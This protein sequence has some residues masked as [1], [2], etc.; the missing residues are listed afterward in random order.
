[1]LS[2]S[3]LLLAQGHPLERAVQE[4][5]AAAGLE[6]TLFAGEPAV[7]Q[8]ILVKCDPR[9]RVWT[10]QYLQYPNPAGLK[11]VQV[12]RWSRTVYDRVPKPPPEGPRGADRI[13]IL[14][15]ADGDGR[16]DRATDFVSGLNLCTGLAFGHGGVFVLQVPYL[17]FYPDR[18][19]DDRPDGPPEV[20]LQ[21]FGM[22]DA[23]SLANHLTWGPDGWLYGVNGST[24]TCRIRGIEFQQGCWRYHP[25]TREFELFC[26]GGGNTFGVTFDEYGRLFYSTNGGPFVHAVQGGY[27]YKS[28]GKH[29]PLHN[30]YAY[31]A[32]PLLERDSV[33]GGPPTGGTIYHGG[34]L[35]QRL[36][37]RFIAGNFLG[38]TVSC[39]EVQSS[40]STVRAKF[41]EV[42]VDSRDTWFGATDLGVM[43]DGSL[44]V[45]DFHD[46]RTSHPDP[47]ATWD[48]S[49]GRIYQI[50]AA[51]ADK[52]REMLEAAGVTGKFDLETFSSERLVE[53]LVHPNR[54]FAERARVILGARQDPAVNPRLRE[55]AVQSSDAELAL[56]ALW[57]LHVN[58]GLDDRTA[59][60]L[61][62][63]AS[64]HLRFWAVRLLGDP[65]Q[66]SPAA[67]KAL[68]KLAGRETHPRVLAQLA[69]TAKRLPAA[70]CLAIVRRLLDRGAGED[71]PRVPWLVWWAIE[72]KAVDHRQE[73]V[74]WLARPES[75]EQPAY[76]GN[77][78]RLIRRLAAEGTEDSYAAA[79][80]LLEPVPAEQLASAA[81]A[82]A[83]GLGERAT[84]LG[85]I[86]QGGLFAEFAEAPEPAATGDSPAVV[87]P[88]SG[89][90]K[91][92]IAKHWKAHL[93][94]PLWI[95]LALD[96]NLANG[97]R[98]LEALLEA[99]ASA[100]EL[101]RQLLAILASHPAVVDRRAVARLLQPGQPE[102]VVAAAM[103]VLGNQ[104]GAELE[105][106]LLPQYAR[107]SPALKSKLRETLL[108]R[109]QGTRRLL[110]LVESGTLTPE[111]IPVEQLR[112]AALHQDPEI[113]AIVKRHWG[114]VGRGTPEEKLALMRRFNNDLRNGTGRAA[115][116]RALFE[117]HCG[118][119]HR[120][121]GQ[122]NQVG[123]DLT[124]TSRERAALLANIVD[125]S[126]V[127]RS[128][129]LSYVVTTQSGQ[130]F[131]GILSDQ[132]A[133]RITLLDAKNQRRQIPR[134][135]VES[136][137]ESPVSLM[138]ERLLEQLT[139]QQ[140][141]DLFAYLQSRP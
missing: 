7:R 96:A 66:V 130:T 102:S 27:Y 81:S 110:A 13:T 78:R 131:T 112:L 40:G 138:P 70:A 136:M 30:P 69:A 37:G 111:E 46:Q 141:C 137:R 91:E 72:S 44:L 88:L 124:A 5:R 127:I 93:R 106:R 57:T 20:L 60:E 135:M 107:L 23:Q 132:N 74:A 126:A 109:P 113:D 48:R 94:E 133:A 12:D 92:W 43:P 56:Q 73:L 80:R 24:T 71:D 122:G 47:D 58:G 89:T 4:M 101:K 2:G 117:K 36:H 63:H 38:H 140:V 129:Y 86:G 61:L 33:P 118:V 87:T 98:Q 99:P 115:A 17:L 77:V 128:N 14:E 119:C 104:P 34:S 39:W 1:M 85:G 53:L 95:G 35:P 49:N 28:F 75:W 29:G 50:R 120:L 64:E 31:H 116:G 9:G 59:I 67:A 82:L 134:E 139:P 51:D 83:A 45:A 25:R 22:E 103:D 84:G 41:S 123:P 26:E 68:E 6:V 19:R 114:R 15:D 90:L 3:T 11:R 125:P 97:R 8:P 100:P 10:I 79:S 62:D 105:E 121:N 52:R 21:G 65:R 32:F 55:L 18:D 16:H 54:W 108:S 76:R 42:L